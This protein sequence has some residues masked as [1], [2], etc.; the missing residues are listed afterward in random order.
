MLDL[1]NNNVDADLSGTGITPNGV[2][3]FAEDGGRGSV[4]T[5]EV[6]E[7][8]GVGGSQSFRQTT[9]STPALGTSYF[10][11]RGFGSFAVSADENNPLAGG[12][13]GS[14]NAAQY[15]FSIDVKVTGNN[16]WEPT[17]PLYFGISASDNDYEATHN[18]DVNNDGDFLDSAEVYNHQVNP[19]ISVSGQWV[20]LSYMF[21]QGTAQTIDPDIPAQDRVFS[22]GLSLQW[23]ASYNSAGFNFDADNVLDVDNIRIEFLAGQNGDYNSD[24]KVDSADYGVWR[25]MP[26]LPILFRTT[27]G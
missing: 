1:Y 9:D 7:T 19:T 24:G 11:V 17:T 18:I 12:V 3:T 22:N 20:H 5:N 27:T 4:F 13:A 14:N 23:Y 21:N 2:W 15:R 10:F 26:A 8:G 6:T 16:G 25:K